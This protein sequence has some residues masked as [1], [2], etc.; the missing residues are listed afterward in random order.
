MD[1]SKLLTSLFMTTAVFVI[2]AGIVISINLM[3]KYE[4]SP[5]IM[6]AGGFILIVSLVYC[7]L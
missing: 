2:T 7:L 6:I 5:Y 1:W 3:V 4:V